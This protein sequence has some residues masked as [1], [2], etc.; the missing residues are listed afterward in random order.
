MV[1]DAASFASKY[2]QQYSAPFK[3]IYPALALNNNTYIIPFLLQGVGGDPK[4]NQQDGI[5]PITAGDRTVAE[6]V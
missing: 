6:N 1:T 5:H 4:L 2:G 3:N